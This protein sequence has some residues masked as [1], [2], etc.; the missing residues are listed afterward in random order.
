MNGV[1]F[2]PIS[3]KYAS[4]TCVTAREARRRLWNVHVMPIARHSSTE[5]DASALLIDQPLTRIAVKP[6]HL[7]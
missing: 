5:G 2:R 6:D 3:S 4:Q 1:A 7:W